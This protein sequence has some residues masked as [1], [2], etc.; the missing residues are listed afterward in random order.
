MALFAEFARLLLSRSEP[1]SLTSDVS[2]G[3]ISSGILI[4]RSI[5]R[6]LIESRIDD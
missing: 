3:V 5:F 6:M 4:G 2:L 1:F